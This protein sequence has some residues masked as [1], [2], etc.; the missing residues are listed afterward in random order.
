MSVRLMI[1]AIPNG[2]G[3]SLLESEIQ[4]LIVK[5][6]GNPQPAFTLELNDSQREVR[7]SYSQGADNNALPWR[8]CGI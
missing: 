7:F 1:V 8:M 5:H 3:G 2:T 6:G 4:K